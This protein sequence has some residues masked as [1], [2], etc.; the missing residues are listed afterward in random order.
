MVAI[1]PTYCNNLYPWGHETICVARIPHITTKSANGCENTPYCNQMVPLRQKSVALGS[2][3]S[4]ANHPL[5]AAQSQ[6]NPH[7]KPASPT[8]L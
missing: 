6:L 4:S 1:R 3:L 5:P 7:T 8:N 2:K